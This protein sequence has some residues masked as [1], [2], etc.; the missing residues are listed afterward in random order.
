LSPR[1]RPQSS[2]HARTGSVPRAAG[3]ARAQS[4]PRGGG[5]AC[6]VGRAIARSHKSGA[7]SAERIPSSAELIP[8][9]QRMKFPG[10]RSGEIRARRASR[11]KSTTCAREAAR[12]TENFPDIFPDVGNL[13]LRRVRA[14]LH[15]PSG[16]LSSR[17]SAGFFFGDL[18][19]TP[20]SGD[21]FP[22]LKGAIHA[23]QPAQIGCVGATFSARHRPSTKLGCGI[24]RLWLIDSR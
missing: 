15:P 22:V 23:S 17:V 24:D 20:R 4:S 9:Y 8:C 18:Q 5:C 14:R 21:V 13:R 11:G 19:S 3:A 6:N 12:A 16:R 1:S 2:A 7:R 10:K